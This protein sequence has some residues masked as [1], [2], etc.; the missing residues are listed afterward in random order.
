MRDLG[1]QSHCEVTVSPCGKKRE[2][3]TEV[4]RG[5]QA[6]DGGNGGGGLT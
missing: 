1:P 5:G 2:L 6:L 3:G 4:T